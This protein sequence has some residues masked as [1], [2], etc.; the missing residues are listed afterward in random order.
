MARQT[1]HFESTMATVALLEDRCLGLVAGHL[2]HDAAGVGFKWR[3]LCGCIL[4]RSRACALQT[5]QYGVRWL[6]IAFK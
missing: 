6:D 4:K 2:A 3:L 1:L 5:A